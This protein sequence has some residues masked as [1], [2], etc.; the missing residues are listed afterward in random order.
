MPSPSPEDM[1]IDMAKATATLAEVCALVKGISAD[2]EADIREGQALWDDGQHPAAF[3]KIVEAVGTVRYK[4]YGLVAP[5]KRLQL[6]V[7]AGANFIESQADSLIRLEMDVNFLK[8]QVAAL[9]KKLAESEIREDAAV[10]A[11]ASLECIV[12]LGQVACTF[13]N[14]FK[15]YVFQ[16]D[17]DVINPPSLRDMVEDYSS[18]TKVQQARFDA[19]MQLVGGDMTRKRMLQA[20]MYLR[21]LCREPAHGNWGKAKTVSI[22][23]LECWALTYCKQEAIPLVVDYVHALAKISKIGKPLNFDLSLLPKLGDV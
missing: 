2:A 9:N 17:P 3:D 16:G 18:L 6:A 4:I 20:D 10:Q 23:Q 1:V 8:K 22:Q 19:V 13:S 14:I 11:K 15:Q 7:E 12:F 5:F 21:N